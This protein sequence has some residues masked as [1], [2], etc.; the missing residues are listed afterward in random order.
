MRRG[1]FCAVYTR[2]RNFTKTGRVRSKLPA[3]RT[4]EFLAGK[5]GYRLNAVNTMLRR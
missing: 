2:I 5:Y 1:D 4:A 3:H